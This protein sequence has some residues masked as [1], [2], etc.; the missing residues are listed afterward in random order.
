MKPSHYSF[1]AI[2]EIS[3]KFGDVICIAKQSI[4]FTV[5][6]YVH[7]RRTTIT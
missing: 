2:H 5:L 3:S 1:K 7:S 4:G 6:H